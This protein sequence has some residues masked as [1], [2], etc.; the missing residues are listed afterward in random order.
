[1]TTDQKEGDIT[2]KDGNGQGS[3]VVPEPKPTPTP[4]PKP[5]PEPEVLSSK[6]DQEPPVVEIPPKPWTPTPPPAPQLP[7][8]KVEVKPKQLAKTGLNATATAGLGVLALLSALVLRRK[9]TNKYKTN[10]YTKG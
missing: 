9:I 6:G 2:W 8:K 4:D 7:P 10:S 3:Y 1:M 5:T